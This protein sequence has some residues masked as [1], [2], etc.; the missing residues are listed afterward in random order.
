MDDYITRQAAIKIARGYCHP[1]NIAKEL[2]KMPS[3]D[4]VEVVRCKDCKRHNLG[5]GDFKEEK[6]GRNTFY[7]KDE[8]CPLI[9]YRGKALGHE[10]DYQF[11]SYGERRTD[12]EIH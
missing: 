7:W 3:A 9:S 11:C 4:V 2:A 12:G 6:V 8:A 1:A 5:I 10:Y